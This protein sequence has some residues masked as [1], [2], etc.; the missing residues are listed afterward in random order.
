MYSQ[1]LTVHQKEFMKRLQE[2][3][4]P[5]SKRLL[6]KWMSQGEVDQISYFDT[7]TGKVSY[8]GRVNCIRVTD[9][10]GY[11]K[12]ALEEAKKMKEKFSEEVKDV[13][14]D[15]KALLVDGASYKLAEKCEHLSV[16]G[17]LFL[18]TILIQDSPDKS[19]SFEDFMDSMTWKDSKPYGKLKT[20][21]E[22]AKKIADEDDEVVADCFRDYCAE[23]GFYGIVLSVSTPRRFYLDNSL[24]SFRFS[25]GTTYS[26]WVY[27]ETFEDAINE[28]LGWRDSMEE[29]DKQR[30]KND[31]GGKTDD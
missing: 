10:Y 14:L 13:E 21:H 8:G 3:D 18:G 26:T 31:Q 25:W 30:Y 15:A 27:G 4:T 20:L 6:K 2:E 7:K 24:K 28:G 9:L 22:K 16:D 19:D 29:L 23:G 11:E 17:V 5:E 12:E 1:R